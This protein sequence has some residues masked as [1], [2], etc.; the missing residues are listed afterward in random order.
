MRNAKRLLTLGLLLVVLLF[1]LAVV[2][3]LA[4]PAGPSAAAAPPDLSWQVIAAGGATLSSANYTML[5]T[6]GQ[7]VAGT[8]TNANYSLLSGYWYGF[9]EF[10]RTILLPVLLKP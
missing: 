3:A 2:A 8:A 1:G 6:A 7:P 5:S 4:L 10:V 9:Q